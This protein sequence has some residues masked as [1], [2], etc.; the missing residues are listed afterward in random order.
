MQTQAKCHV[1]AFKFQ[2]ESPRIQAGKRVRSGCHLKVNRAIHPI[3]AEFGAYSG[4]CAILEHPKGQNDAYHGE[5]T[6]GVLRINEVGPG[7]GLEVVPYSCP[8]PECLSEYYQIRKEHV[9]R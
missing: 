1:L 6:S 3:R 7:D 8:V 5:R 4:V 9:A 2:R